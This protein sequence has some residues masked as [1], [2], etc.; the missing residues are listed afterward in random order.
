MVVAV[1]FVGVVAVASTASADCTVVPTVKVGSTG[2]SVTCVQSKVGVTA[3]GSFGP[4]TKAAVMAYQAA[5][6]LTADGVVGPMSA[7]KMNSVASSGNYPAGCTSSMGYSSTTGAKCDGGSSSS[8]NGPLTGGA[9]TL[10]FTSTTANTESKVKEGATEKVLA[11]KAE[12]DGSDIGVTAVKVILKNNGYASS[13]ERLTDY[14]DS[15]SIYMG[16]TKVGEED[17]SDFSK[18][19]DSPDTFTKTIS[20]SNAVVKDGVK[21]TFYVA[22]TANDSIESTDMDADWNVEADT[23]RYTDA[24][25]IVL[26]ESLGDNVTLTDGFEDANVDDDISIKSS[27]SNPVAS[28]LQVEANNSSDQFLLGVFKLDV[29]DQS[30]D[31]SITTVTA[32]LT[33]ND[34]S[35]TT[36]SDDAADIIDEVVFKIDGTDYTADLDSETVTD[37]DGDGIYSVDLDSGDL[38][39]NAGDSVDVKIYAS[40][41][42]QSGNYGPGTTVVASVTGSSDIDAE[43]DNDDVTVS[44]SF[45]GKTHTLSVDAPTF[46]LVSKSFSLYQAIDGV[47]TGEED[48]F[49]A[50][51][52]FNVTAADEDVYLSKGMESFDE[53]NYDTAGDETQF[54]KTNGGT[55]ESAVLDADDSTLDD[56]LTSSFLVTSGSTEKF[57]LSFY[58]R[59]ANNSAI[60]QVDSFAYGTADDASTQYEYNSAVSSGLTAFVTNSTYLAK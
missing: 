47:A 13:S 59:G 27:S 36:A 5:N 9:G 15:V 38:T 40:F 18:E 4:M 42:D 60:V 37:G 33:I 34:A 50:K 49:L 25:G 30:S 28:T 58:V 2:A 43:T 31:V 45:T 17:A 10:D 54:T 21:A 44:G 24:T 29:D 3:D 11:F 53:A 14:V 20:L 35:D 48:I 57:T 7:A 8:S 32:T 41:N 39:I 55:L 52:V 26:S 1:M 46:E 16:S 23:V 51:F 22:L 12:A 56:G 6:G 19:A